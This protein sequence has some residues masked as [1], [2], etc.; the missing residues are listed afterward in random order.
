M[1]RRKYIYLCFLNKLNL[2]L[3]EKAFEWNEGYFILWNDA[4]ID[5]KLKG[6]FIEFYDDEHF[7]SGKNCVTYEI[8]VWHIGNLGKM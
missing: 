2:Y 6:E 1:E 8:V 5:G 4:K 7:W 3:I